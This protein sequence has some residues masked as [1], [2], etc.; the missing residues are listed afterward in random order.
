VFVR[1]AG[2]LHDVESKL[3]LASVQPGVQDQLKA[4]GMMDDLGQANV[5]GPGRWRTDTL[6]TAYDDATAW[7]AT[8]RRPHQWVAR[9]DDDHTS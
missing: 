3:V 8:R 5:Y 9:T 2:A 4:T 6:L 1:Y 7:V